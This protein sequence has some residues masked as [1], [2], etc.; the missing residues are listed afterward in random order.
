MT[1]L[2]G[3][4]AATSQSS[5]C[6]SPNAKS[7]EDR[8]DDQSDERG[9]APQTAVDAMGPTLGGSTSVDGRERTASRDCKESQPLL[10]RSRT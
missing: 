7:E 2:R 8:G 3:A 5:Q 9:S 6:G 10:G 1:A 4:R